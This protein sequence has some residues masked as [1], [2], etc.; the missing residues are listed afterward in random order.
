MKAHCMHTQV[1][2]ITNHHKGFLLL[3]VI[4][5]LFLLITTVSGIA[6][7]QA[8]THMLCIDAKKRHEA[9]AMTTTVIETLSATKTIIPLTVH[10]DITV[11]VTPLSNYYIPVT[12]IA[13]N[14]RLLFLE[15]TTSW[16]TTT[17]LPTSMSCII[18]MNV[19]KEV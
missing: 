2:Q 8:H 7:Y 16:K 6:V 5:A 3:E 15:V 12:A 10:D 11:T 17:I 13:H 1:Y 9:L 4:I 14:D 18:C 19:I